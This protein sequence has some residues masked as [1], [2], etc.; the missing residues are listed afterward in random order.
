MNMKSS[1]DVFLGVKKWPP[2]PS[3]NTSPQRRW[4]CGQRKNCPATPH[5]ECVS[6]EHTLTTA[7]AVF[8]SLIRSCN[9][10][11]LPACFGRACKLKQEEKGRSKYFC[12]A[13]EGWGMSFMVT[14]LSLKLQIW[15]TSDLSVAD[16]TWQLLCK[17]GPAVRMGSGPLAGKFWTLCS[18]GWG[19]LSL[20]SWHV[21]VE[22]LDLL[23]VL[24]CNLWPS[25]AAV[26]EPLSHCSCK[27]K[28]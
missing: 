22:M 27:F 26:I 14:P 11:Q 16:C 17:C 18:V 21:G 4:P 24:F 23:Y 19:E 10:L 25:G 1:A 13:E 12:R 20:W 3:T 2:L 5:G 28:G 6:L 7:L 9:W 15:R 8:L